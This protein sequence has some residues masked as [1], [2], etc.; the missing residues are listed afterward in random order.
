MNQWSADFN[1]A[2]DGNT[3][4]FQALGQFSGANGLELTSFNSYNLVVQSTPYAVPDT[5]MVWG[6]VVGPG[7]PSPDP[8]SGVVG[9]FDIEQGNIFIAGEYGAD[10]GF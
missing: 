10:L 5:L 6:S 9:W 1:M 4:S 8:I 2:G 3:L 7:L